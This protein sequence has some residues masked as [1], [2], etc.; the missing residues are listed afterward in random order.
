MTLFAIATL[1]PAGLIAA[2][3][4]WGSPFGLLGLAIMTLVSGLADQILPENRSPD[5]TDTS[6][7]RLAVALALVHLGLLALVVWALAQDQH[8]FG[9]KLA[10]FFAA[11]LYFGQISN[12]NAHELIHRPQRALRM[13]GM[14]VYIS[15]LYG[16]HHSAHPL[17]HH[18]HVGTAK[19]P[20]TARRGEGFYRYLIRAWR[21][22][23][24]AGFR[25][26][27]ARLARAGRASWR[28]PYWVYL[29]GS[30]GFGALALA[31]GGAAGLWAYVSLAIYAQIQLLLS[32]Y[33]QHYGLRRAIGADGR[34]EPVSARH[35]W[36]S[37]HPVSALMLLHATRHSDHHTSPARPYPALAL[38]DDA[39]MLPH[40]LPLMASIALIP[41]LWRRIMDPLADRWRNV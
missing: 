37:P 36:N 28:N 3:A 41:P 29:G 31:L 8:D 6:G 20:N 21:G 1:L 12:A 4:V 18:S 34:P 14:W 23:F 30:L 7:T 26:E 11:G 35:S 40:P 16:Q 13:L 33:V 5:D 15:L 38:P 22:E 9:A 19:D 17:V 2:G 39:P 10:L 24:I 32:D 27:Q 25:A